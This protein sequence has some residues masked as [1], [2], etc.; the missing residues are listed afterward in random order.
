MNSKLDLII[1][2]MELLLEQA[3]QIMAEVPEVEPVPVSINDSNVSLV[4][5][6]EASDITGIAEQTLKKYRLEGLI[7]HV[8]LQGRIFYYQKDLE[9]IQ[10][11]I[12]PKKNG[13]VS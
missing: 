9:D 1:K 11:M 4:S 7:K 5:Q 13:G 10:K 3:K 2:Q 6:S 8:T 12:H